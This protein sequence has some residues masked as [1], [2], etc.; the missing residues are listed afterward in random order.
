M[1]RPQ[2][3][4]AEMAFCLVMPAPRRA[5]SRT[6]IIRASYEHEKCYVSSWHLAGVDASGRQ[7]LLLG[8][9]RTRLRGAWR[10]GAVT[11]IDWPTVLVDLVRAP[12]EVE[13]LLAAIVARLAERLQ[14]AEAKR[15]PVPTVRL[16]VVGDGRWRG[17]AS[18]EA[19]GAQ[20]VVA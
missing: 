2:P 10:V 18:C 20:R 11:P 5:R 17:D 4:A 12:I 6:K 14:C 3:T 15:I 8:A 1:S 9:Q 19:H 7:R 16:D 13:Q